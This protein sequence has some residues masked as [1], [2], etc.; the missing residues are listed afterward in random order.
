MNME[1][2]FSI[3]TET[4]SKTEKSPGTYF[5]DM[6]RDFDDRML[7]RETI[8]IAFRAPRTNRLRSALTMLGLVIGVAAPGPQTWPRRPR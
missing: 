6:F 1:S 3:H 4:G 2:P 5:T 7:L 8:R